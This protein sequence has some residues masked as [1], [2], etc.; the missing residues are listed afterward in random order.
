MSRFHF[1]DPAFELPDTDA[2]RLPN[3][4]HLPMIEHSTICN[5]ILDGLVQRIGHYD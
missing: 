4:G 5:E 1:S 3:C 2:Q